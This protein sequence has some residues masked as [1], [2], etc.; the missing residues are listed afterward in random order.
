MVEII[1]VL[2]GPSNFVEFVIYLAIGGALW[3]LFDT[4]FLRKFVAPMV[5]YIINGIITFGV[6]ILLLNKLGWTDIHFPN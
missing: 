5:R 2:A 3:L 6:L 4:F 1:A